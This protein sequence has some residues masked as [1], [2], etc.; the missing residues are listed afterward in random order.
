MKHLPQLLILAAIITSLIVSAAPLPA[1]AQADPTPILGAPVMV[2]PLMT[3]AASTQAVA[4]LPTQGS[5]S[6]PSTIAEATTRR[7]SATPDTC[8]PNDTPAQPC[9]LPLDTVSGPFTIVPERDQDFYLLDLPQEASIQ[10]L[11]TAHSTAGLD[12]VLSARQGD[13]LVASGTFSLTL[14]PTVVGPVVLRVENRDPRPAAGEQYRIEVRR[15]IVAPSRPDSEQQSTSAPDILENNWSFDTTSAIAVGLVYDLTFVCPDPR[16]DACPGGDHDHLLVPVKAGMA[17]LIATFDLDPGVDTVVELFWGSTATA[18][19]GNDDYAPGGTLSALHWTAPGD[20]LLGIRLAPRNGGLHQQLPAAKTGY[21]FAVAPVAGELARKL[22][23]MIR[24]QANAPTPTPAAASAAVL[25][26]GATGGGSGSGAPAQSAPPPAPAVT[27]AQESIAAGP[28]IILRETVLR[29]EPREGATAL[30]TLT[31]E[32]HVSVRG[33]VSGLWVS[34]DT[35]ASILPGWVRWSDLQ[36]VTTPSSDAA[37][38]ETASPAAP[39][40]APTV[41]N[42]GPPDPFSQQPFAAT[43]QPPT[44]ASSGSSETSIVS[45]TALDPALP[46]PPPPPIA[47]VP[48]TLSIVVAAT[49]RPPTASSALGMSTPTPDLSRPVAQVRVQLLNVF[50]DVLAEGLT[51]NQGLVTLSRDVRPGQAL[52]VRMPAWGVELPLA[53]QQ[54]RLIVTIPEAKQ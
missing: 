6:S 1:R 4:P 49:D 30:A 34:I 43:S 12:L 39:A 8:E 36:R 7:A 22:E 15:G 33:P 11:I 31:A 16:P 25:A 46:S 48:F 9:R 23:E 24:E 45:V 13:S 54:S 41:Q 2:T 52:H 5:P 20:G 19:A 26:G 53:P 44:G 10:T 32:T 50:G 42:G 27:T 35:E 18:V 14:A 38:A 3:P 28:A 51:D 29:R 17:Y 40:Q 21:R 47:R 37:V